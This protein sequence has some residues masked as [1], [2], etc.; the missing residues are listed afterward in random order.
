[1]LDQQVHIPLPDPFDGEHAKDDCQFLG[2][3][4]HAIEQEHLV[5]ILAVHLRPIHTNL[6]LL[7]NHCLRS[8][9]YSLMPSQVIGFFQHCC[10]DGFN[11]LA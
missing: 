10:F 1:M 7:R 2:G 6:G 4:K 9:A 11:A 5:V 8:L 3:Q